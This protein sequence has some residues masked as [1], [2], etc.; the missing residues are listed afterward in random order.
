[1]A[2]IIRIDCK[3][4]ASKLIRIKSLSSSMNNRGLDQ[5]KETTEKYEVIPAGLRI[6][7]NLSILRDELKGVGQ[8]MNLTSW[9]PVG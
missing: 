2:K 5:W 6:W 9:S 8:P 1:M 7:W 3:C 4:P